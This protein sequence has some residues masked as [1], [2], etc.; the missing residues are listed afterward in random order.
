MQDVSSRRVGVGLRPYRAAVLVPSDLPDENWDDLIRSMNQ[1]WGG[2]TW[3]IVPTDG[4]SIHQVFWRHLQA[5]GPDLICRFGKNIEESLW[6]EI[7]L[8]LPLID[9]TGDHVHPIWPGNLGWP[10]APMDAALTDVDQKTLRY[11][12]VK[13]APIARAAIHSWSGL[14]PVET[15]ERLEKAGTNIVSES[16]E[17]P[18]SSLYTSL[19]GLWGHSFNPPPGIFA[20]WLASEHLAIF[21][22]STPQM[23]PLVVVCGQSLEDFALFWNL[24]TLRGF[25]LSIMTGWL[26][27][28][29]PLESGSPLTEVYQLMSYAIEDSAR[30]L[31][32]E[33]Q[34]LVTSFSESETDL[35][36]VGSYLSEMQPIK[37]IEPKPP[38]YE[39]VAVDKSDFSRLVPYE[40][41]YWEANNSPSV[42]SSIVQFSDRQ[43]LSLLNTPVPR[44][45]TVD[46]DSKLR[47]MAEAEIE[48]MAPPQRPEVSKLFLTSGRLAGSKVAKK[49][50]AYEA[51]GGLRMSYMSVESMLVRP[52]ISCPTDADIMRAITAARG[53]RIA[54][55]NVGQ[56]EDQFVRLAGNLVDAANFLKNPVIAS[57]FM[58]FTDSSPNQTGVFDNGALIAGR[59]YADMSALQNWCPDDETAKQ[60]ADIFLQRQIFQR[61]FAIKCPFCRSADWYSIRELS[62]LAICHQCGREQV[63]DAT[64][65]VFFRL[66]E[67]AFKAI[68]NGS[69]GAILGLDRIQSASES[70]FHFSH[71]IEIWRDEDKVRPWLEV[72]FF[73]VSDN[74]V[75]IGEVKQ[76]GSLTAEDKRQLRRYLEFARMMDTDELIVVTT[77]DHWTDGATHFFDEL[78]GRASPHG[79]KISLLNGQEIEWS[80]RE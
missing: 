80:P 14:L 36:D 57:V 41:S 39:W 47:W 43:A 49:G 54:L 24:R 30:E 1:A 64:A 38:E 53:L 32:G 73:V 48:G 60:I 63:Y 59:R 40:I 11:V 9:M 74:R 78:R 52:R 46:A 13:G 20:S 19:S 29:L 35:A 10:F 79:I 45:M 15:T 70:G 3:I 72:D 65:R 27:E 50:V 26:P 42:N 37:T 67:I 17:L 23:H 12:E 8:R 44:K 76:K 71:A 16:I 6:S 5:Y 68:R 25:P 61:G 33:K 7:N 28:M 2:M 55:S 58:K 75:I 34:I 69:Y 56:I 66:N 22:S 77:Q 21:G 51:L 4:S 31:F 62:D 18:S